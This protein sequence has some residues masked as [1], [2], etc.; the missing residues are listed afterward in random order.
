MLISRIS[1]KNL[2]LV[3]Q[4]MEVSSMEDVARVARAASWSPSSFKDSLR[5]SDQFQETGLIVLDVDEGCTLDN[6]KL[7]FAPFKHAILTSRNHQKEKNGVTCDRYRVILQLDK[8]VTSVDHFKAVYETM[9]ADFPF[10]DPACADAARFFY[11]SP[12]LVSLSEEGLEISTDVK[13]APAS[14]VSS[15]AVSGGPKG[16]LWKS[17]L[18][19]IA[20]GAAAGTRHNALVKAVGNMREQNYSLAEVEEIMQGM[21][22][23]PNAQWTQ[24]GLSRKDLHTIRDVFKRPD[25]YE[26]RPKMSAVIDSVLDDMTSAREARA[27]TYVTASDVIQDTF[28]YL[29]D[30]E[31]VKGDPSGVEGLDRLL[32][33]GF[34]AGELT[35]L[36]ASAKT[37]KNTLYHYLMYE[38]LKKGTPFGYASRELTPATEVVPNLLSLARQES[39]WHQE[40]TETYQAQAKEE[41]AKWP[42]YF[43][44]G[45]GYFPL[46]EMKQWFI[47]LK[48]MGV[49]HFLVD[50][51]HYILQSEEY[52]AVAKTIKALKTLTKELD[53]HLNLIVQP[54]SLR[55]G[56]KLSLATLR[57]GAAIGQALDNLLILERVRGQDNI[58]QLSLEVARHKLARLGK[59]YLKY[60]PETTAFLE[61]KEELVQA[62]E[63]EEN[64]PRPYFP[65]VE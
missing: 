31:K 60:L 24:V 51:F 57:G 1:E 26:F 41:V 21:S 4:Y 8:T 19:L 23:N 43:A 38:M 18:D 46:E 27:A 28:D 33:G 37:G 61:V 11:P 53:I 36:M 50:H 17:T 62:E 49:Q 25:K 2:G 65:R 35:V 15:Q 29:S 54:R 14:P 16:D 34:R 9:K 5:R 30:K 56:E 40:I 10:V 32:G 20:F 12:E 42:L 48:E 3:T 52:D 47:Q 55:E 59:I 13:V 63:R 7:I 45:Y 22:L 64:Q 44:P 58:S 39:A 6:A